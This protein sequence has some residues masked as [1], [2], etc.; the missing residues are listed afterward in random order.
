MASTTQPHLRTPPAAECVL[1][2][3]AERYASQTP[4]RIF[5]VFEAGEPWRWGQVHTELTAMAAGLR[6]LGLGWQDKL[7]VWLPNGKLAL[8]AMFAA[9]YL[10]GISVAINTAYRG[11]LLE[12]VLTNSGA[13]LSVVHPDL[14]ERLLEVA[15][16][17]RLTT[18]LTTDAAAADHAAAFA[19][20][21]LQ[22]L[23]LSVLEG[24]PDPALPVAGIEPWTTQSIVYTSG[25]TGPSKGVLSSYL[26][27]CTMG[28]DTLP[29]LVA[30]DRYM[31]NLPLFHAGA[32]LA[33]AGAVA[34]GSSI[35][36]INGFSTGSFLATCARLEVTVTILLGVMM[37]FLLRHPPGPADRDHSLRLAMVHY[38]PR[39]SRVRSRRGSSGWSRKSRS[40][41]RSA[42][43]PVGPGLLLRLWLWLWLCGS[44]L[45]A[46]IAALAALHQ[47]G[48]SGQFDP[49]IVT[50]DEGAVAVAGQQVADVAQAHFVVHLGIT[51][52][53]HVVAEAAVIG[54]QHVDP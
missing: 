16:P 19:A 29:Q 24:E 6:R 30:S 42:F 39:T 9:N 47:S 36:V 8:S 4:D 32:T 33:I 53:V 45:V 10:G 46:K 54:P 49:W 17:G 28:I 12:H 35:A 38:G 41:D 37:S 52:A 34:R 21:G 40:R 3:L 13:V 7:L 27:L 15:S 48:R 5:A 22:L 25:T 14:L 11:G 44:H 23:G 31:I 18:V 51:A 43:P 1:P 26:H 20:A 2:Y 50:F